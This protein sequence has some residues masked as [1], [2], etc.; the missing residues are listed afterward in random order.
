MKKN[1]I[2]SELFEVQPTW[3]VGCH[4]ENFLEA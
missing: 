2:L 4:K 1:I 3:A